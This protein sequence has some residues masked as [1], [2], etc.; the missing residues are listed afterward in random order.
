MFKGPY[1]ILRGIGPVD[2]DIRLPNGRHSVIV[3]Q[4]RLKP[5]CEE[6]E[7]SE[8]ET[9]DDLHELEDIL[10]ATIPE[11]DNTS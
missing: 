9:D 3:H 5:C 10:G 7:N 11:L 4:R 6:N 1:I 8:I 2:Y